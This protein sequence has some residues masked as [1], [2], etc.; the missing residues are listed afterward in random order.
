MADNYR[1]LKMVSDASVLECM[2]VYMEY[3]IVYHHVEVG[4]WTSTHAASAFIH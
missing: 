1:D 4:N 2:T 3:M